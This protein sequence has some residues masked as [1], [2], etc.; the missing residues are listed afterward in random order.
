MVS[1]SFGRLEATSGSDF[2]YFLLSKAAPDRFV[3]DVVKEQINSVIKNLGIKPPS[4]NGAFGSS[5]EFKDLVTDIG[6]TNDTNQTITRRVLFLT[7]ARCVSGNDV[8][9]DALNE[10]LKRYVNDDISE[11][12]LA[13]FFLNDIIRYWR[14]ICVDF[15]NKVF[16]GGK[17]WGI[18]NIKLIFSRKLLYFGGVVTAAETA[19]RTPTQK[20]QIMRSLI[21]RSPTDRIRHVFGVEAERTLVLYNE[22]LSQLDNIKFRQMLEETPADRKLHSEDF[23]CI[24]NLGQ[25]F[26]LE[27]FSLLRRRY[28]EYHPIYK[29]MLF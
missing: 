27:L 28:T 23:R 4:A 2:D 24:K 13:L 5:L 21:G 6:G 3:I 15:E 17:E 1:G 12:Q 20:R 26:T 22:F 9:D 11:H 19:Q 7:E 18:R 29:S 14:T 16:E 25:H 10:L 8:F